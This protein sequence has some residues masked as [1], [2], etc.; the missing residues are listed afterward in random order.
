MND[1]VAHAPEPPL[2]A[3]V[4]QNVEFLAASGKAMYDAAAGGVLGKGHTLPS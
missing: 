2:N 4:K 3:P 1:I